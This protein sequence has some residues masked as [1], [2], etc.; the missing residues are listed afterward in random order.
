MLACTHQQL[1]PAPQPLQLPDAAPSAARRAQSRRLTWRLTAVLAC[2]HQQLLSAPKPLQLPEAAPSAARRAQSRRLT[3][4]LTA[5]LA[6]TYQQLLSAPKPLQLP[7][8]AS[9]SSPQSA[10]Q[11]SDMEAVSGAGLHVPA[12]PAS[13][14]ASPA[15]GGSTPSSS[16]ADS[17]RDP[18]QPDHIEQASASTGADF[19]NT[20]AAAAAPTIG[21]RPSAPAEDELSMPSA[22]GDLGP[23][24]QH[25][26]PPPDVCSSTAQP[27]DGQVGKHG[28]Q[29]CHMI[30]ALAAAP[31]VRHTCIW[32]RIQ[33]EGSPEALRMA[34]VAP[35]FHAN[36]GGF[37][38]SACLAAPADPCTAQVWGSTWHRHICWWHS[39]VLI[40]DDQ[41]SVTCCRAPDD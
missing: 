21:A 8:A 6:C 31:S 9:L 12:A 1:L 34:S 28:H 40:L 16:P 11:A 25:Q 5:V 17:P 39:C 15:A 33:A 22:A 18:P 24:I 2:T 36:N 26:Q 4:R 13:P 41:M 32:V 19:S 23:E 27:A 3:W 14:P 7:E 29:T 20:S 37:R 30:H 38:I 35:A 10:E